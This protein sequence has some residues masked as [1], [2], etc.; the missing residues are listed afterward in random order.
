M[1]LVYLFQQKNATLEMQEILDIKNLQTQI[2]RVKIETF[3]KSFHI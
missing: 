3:I 1:D 2:S